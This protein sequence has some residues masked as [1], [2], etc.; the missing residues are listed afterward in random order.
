MISCFVDGGYDN[1]GKRNGYGSFA[2]F[3]S[4]NV[5]LAF[6]TFKLP[7]A[8]SSNQAEYLSLL[9]LITKI[10]ELNLSETTIINS[11]SQLMIRQIT[12]EYRVKNPKLIELHSMVKL[13]SN[14]V[15]NWVPRKVNVEILG[16]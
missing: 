11:D 6:E 12:G 9:R 2:I 15:L 5:Q 10:N 7:E 3:T 4:E 8:S 1:V 13:P 14:C 16:H